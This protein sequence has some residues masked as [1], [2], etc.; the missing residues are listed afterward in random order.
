MDFMPVIPTRKVIT[1]PNLPCSP[2]CTSTRSE[3]YDYFPAHGYYAP[4][5]VRYRFEP[6]N[7]SI[8]A[9]DVQKKINA[10]HRR[11]ILSL[12]YVAAYAASESI[13]RKY[14]YPMTDANGARKIFNGQ[15]MSETEAE[16]Q[17]KP[18]WFWI[19]NIADDS[20]WYDY[21][22]S[23]FRRTLDDKPGDLV[24]FDGF[25]I[26]TYGDSINSKF[27][28]IG[29]KR[30]GDLLHDVLRDFVGDVRTL[31]HK[32]KPHGL[33]SFNSVNEFAV[34]NMYGVTDF[35]FLEIWRSHTENLEDMVD[36]CFRHRAPRRQRVILKVYPADMNPGK[37]VWSEA[38][39]RRLLGATMTGAGSLMVVG[40]PDE[41]T[42]VM[43]GLN[44]LYYP[45]HKPIPSRNEDILRAYY[46]HD[47]LLFGYTHGQNVVN[48][49][50]RPLIPGCVTRTYAALSKRAIVI[51]LL[52]VGTEPRWS[53]DT[54]LPTPEVNQQVT[55]KLPAGVPPRG[56]YFASPDVPALQTPVKLDF[57]ISGG[58][59]RILLPELR[60]HGT[61]ILQY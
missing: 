8:N 33:V 27:Y 45:D 20:K 7:T 49:D 15:I 48:T 18:K 60:V 16:Q 37:T 19:M 6:F 47:A 5:E 42:G 12:A 40:E 30:N 53:V 39:L 13:Y 46:S 44:T 54:T 41:K 36:I 38:S 34:K 56:V 23:E 59:L 21:I 11:N 14:P 22:M 24:S 58:M 35:L 50:L 57:Q 31:T 10:G 32:I 43:H 28:A 25:E 17:K 9:L 3:F 26:D 4:R 51:Q 29:S 61:L 52:H 55:I 1:P 2:G